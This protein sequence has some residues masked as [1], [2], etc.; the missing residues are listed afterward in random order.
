[1]LF[2]ITFRKKK[3]KFLLGEYFD[4]LYSGFVSNEIGNFYMRRIQGQNE[5]R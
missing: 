4:S 3:K 2:L 5:R 1:M